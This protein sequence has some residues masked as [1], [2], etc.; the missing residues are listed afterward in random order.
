VKAYW[1]K[2]K[3]ERGS[4]RDLAV[5]NDV[6]DSA[7]EETAKKLHPQGERRLTE[8]SVDFSSANRQSPSPQPSG[9]TRMLRWATGLGHR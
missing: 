8:I 3:T 6:D 2:V 5:F 7:A 1:L 4:W 9:L